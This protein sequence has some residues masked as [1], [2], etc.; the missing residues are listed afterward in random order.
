MLK[1]PKK[2]LCFLSVFSWPLFAQDFYVI[3]KGDVLSK[4]LQRNFPNQPIYGKNGKLSEIMLMNPKIKNPHLIYPKTSLILRRGSEKNNESRSNLE[5][6]EEIKEVNPPPLK[7]VRTLSSVEEIEHWDISATYGGKFVS[8]SQDGVLGDADLGVIF[9]Q[10]LKLKS[11]YHHNLWSFGMEFESYK[12]KYE[13]LSSKGSEDMFKMDIYSSYKWMLGG[14]SVDDQTP[15]LKNDNG[16]ISAVRQSLVF[17]SLGVKKDISLPTK[18]PTSIKL[19]SVARYALD[20]S[21]DSPEIEVSSVNGFSVRGQIEF[22]R[23]IYSKEDYSL[24]ASW[25]NDFGYQKISQKINWETSAGNMSS[26]FIDASTAL[27]L[28]VRF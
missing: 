27:G 24:S 28:M 12:F 18:K 19:K 1:L 7:D 13:T 20:G 25:M 6:P 23:Q 14:L 5:A 26:T 21:T 16:D 8:L 9:L 11:V 3:Q 2:T 17:L 22:L 15:L 4:I 10:N